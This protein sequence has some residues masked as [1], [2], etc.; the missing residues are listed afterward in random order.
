MMVMSE[1]ERFP[2]LED[3]FRFADEVVKKYPKMA[4]KLNEWRDAAHLLS[5]YARSCNY[6]G[7]ISGAQELERTREEAIRSATRRMGADDAGSFTRKILEKEVNLYPKI[8]EI[9]KKVCNCK[10]RELETVEGPI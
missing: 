2:E 7:L 5:K 1:V 10:P 3:L 8:E 4:D 6:I 9:L